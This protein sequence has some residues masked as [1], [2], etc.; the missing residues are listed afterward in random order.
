MKCAGRKSVT[1]FIGGKINNFLYTT[2]VAIF[3]GFLEY[4]S[5]VKDVSFDLNVLYFFLAF[6]L[7]ENF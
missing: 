4:L 5:N 7:Q 3:I 2:D 6:L 1:G